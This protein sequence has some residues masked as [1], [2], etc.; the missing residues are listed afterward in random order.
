MAVK[1]FGQFLIEQDAITGEALVRAV[2][3]QERTNLKLGEMAVALGFVTPQQI[4]TAHAAQ[5]SKDMK[6]GELLLELGFLT[7]SQ[8]EEVLSHQKATHLYIGEALVKIGA[9]TPEKLE[10]YLEAFRA[11]QAP[12]IAERVELPTWLSVDAAVWEMAVDMTYKMI[13]R[14]IGIQFR[15]ARY[16]EADRLSGGGLIAAMDMHGDLN[17]RYLLSVSTTV[18]NSIALAMLKESS[19]EQEPEELLEDTVLEFVNVICGNIAAKASQMGIQLQIDPPVLLHQ[20]ADGLPVPHGY[21]GIKFPIVVRED[22][23][24]EMALFIKQ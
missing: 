15:P 2:E 22:D 18:R 10:H 20:P 16:Q 11:D 23:L 6:L 14:V 19:V 21:R 1:F 5:L 9:L 7:L 3:L 12:F 8:L 17:A 24:M 13:T 4:E